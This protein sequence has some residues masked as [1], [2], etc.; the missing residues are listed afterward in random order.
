M[1]PCLIHQ[2]NDID[3]CHDCWDEVDR[4]REWLERRGEEDQS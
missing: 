1:K 4:L 2:Q 3:D